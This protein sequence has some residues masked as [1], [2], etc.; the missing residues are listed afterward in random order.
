MRRGVRA[1]SWVVLAATLG[2]AEGPVLASPPPGGDVLPMTP[3]NL[4]RLSKGL[5]AEEAARKALAAKAPKT[6]SPGE[7]DQCRTGVLSGP[8]AMKLMEDFGAASQKAGSD[9][10]AL[11]KAAE[12]M[13]KGM[14]AL[15]EKRCGPDPAAGRSS[16]QERQREM[17]DAAARDAGLT[18][19]QYAVLKERVTP[20]CALGGAAGKEGARIKAPGGAYWV[21]TA[22]EVSALGPRCAALTKA[23]R[24]ETP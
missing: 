5:A 7:Y 3:E 8:D 15:V 16:A 10:A 21:Y 20:F 9:T 19:R 17:A 13:Q 6:K 24:V 11:V 2:L 12:A 22:A 18:P 23:L 14:D 4:D 1:V